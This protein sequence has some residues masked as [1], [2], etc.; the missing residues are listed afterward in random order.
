MSSTAFFF[1]AA[2]TSASLFSLSSL[3]SPN[4]CTPSRVFL[5]SSSNFLAASGPLPFALSS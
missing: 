1:L 4:A 2:A 5:Y 3:L